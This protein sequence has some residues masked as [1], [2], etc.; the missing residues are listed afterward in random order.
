MWGQKRSPTIEEAG[1]GCIGY[2]LG[3]C[4]VLYVIYW[5]IVNIIAPGIAIFV[6]VLCGMGIL[7]GGGV[8]IHNFYQA[9]VNNISLRRVAVKDQN[10]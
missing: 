10:Q 7:A 9:C 1:A 2:L 8:S 3:I 5:V 6:S 4:L